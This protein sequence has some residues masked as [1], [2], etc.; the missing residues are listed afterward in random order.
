MRPSNQKELLTTSPEV[1]YDNQLDEAHKVV[2]DFSQD[3]LFIES[4]L[5][6]GVD[7]EDTTS[8]GYMAALSAYAEDY[9]ANLGDMYD[10]RVVTEISL[11]ANAPLM[12][13]VS[14]QIQHYESQRSGGH[15]LNQES[16]SY[17]QN[18][19]KPYSVWFNQKLSDYMVDHDTTKFSDIIEALTDTTLE[20]FPHHEEDVESHLTN[21]ARGART[22]AVGRQ[23]VALTGLQYAPGTPEDDLRGGDI[24]VVYKGKRIKIDFKSSL[25]QIAKHIGGY[26]A[27]EEKH[28]MYAVRHFKRDKYGSILLFPGFTDGD[29]GDACRLPQKVAEE[30]AFQ[31]SIQ[32]QRAFHEMHL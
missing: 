18:E 8:Y 12:I 20:H 10:P 2:S 24:V 30:R 32:L 13:Y 17:L 4:L 14:N 11:L 29:L 21:I 22:E 1:A 15:R 19:L 3:S 16:W 31:M 26:D 5:D 9:V 27:V 23:L 6:K 7:P 28:Q 25:D